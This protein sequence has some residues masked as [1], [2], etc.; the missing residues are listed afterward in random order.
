MNVNPYTNRKRR[1]AMWAAAAL[2]AIGAG[3]ATAQEAYPSRPIKIIVPI[4][5]GA[6]ADTVPR[7]VGEKLA[8][9]WG[10][11]VI[12]ENR[13]GAALNIGAEAVA[14]AAPDGYTL[15]ASPP[16]PLTVNQSLYP[17]LGFDPAAF[18][19]VTVLAQ[20]PN[21]LVINPKTPVSNLEQLLEF[22]R[23]NPDKLTYASSGVGGTPHLSMELLKTLTGIK[24]RHV[25]YKG[26]APALTDLMAGHV[27]MMFDNLGN[28]AAPIEAGTLNALAVGSD[29]RI[30]TLPAVPAMAEMFPGFVSVAWFAVVAPP[31]TPREIAEKLS[32]TIGEIVRQGDITKKFADLYSVPIGSTPDQTAAFIK[33]ERDRWSKVIVTAGIKPD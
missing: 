32:R 25:P 15:L 27:D 31:G 1:A 19:P 10:Q 23:S 8:S 2:I 26:L 9:L 33:D 17:K 13:P 7:L 4:P 29:K 24:I 28:V 11:P 14:R 6:T 16:P 12:I 21:L 18:V 20:V 22:A 30:A 5:P 3:I